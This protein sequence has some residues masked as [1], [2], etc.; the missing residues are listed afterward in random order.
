MKISSKLCCAVLVVAVTLSG[1]R[2]SREEDGLI[3]DFLTKHVYIFS[4]CA[5]CDV[6]N[7]CRSGWLNVVIPGCVE[8]AN[9]A[10]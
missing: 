5:A 10:D 8:N 2:E 1:R 4:Q 3:S 6:P 9:T 7:N